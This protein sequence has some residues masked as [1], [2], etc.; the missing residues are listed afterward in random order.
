MRCKTGFEYF[1][2]YYGGVYS[3]R[4]MLLTGRSGAGKTTFGLQFLKAGIKEDEPGLIIS[5]Q[6]ARNLVLQ[7][8]ELGVDVNDP[9]VSQKLF[10]F[11]YANFIPGRDKEE[12][13]A[14]PVE[15][16]T[17]LRAAIVSNGIRRL[18]LDTVLP[19]LNGTPFTKLPEEMFSFIQMLDDLDVTTVLTLPKPASKAALKLQQLIELSVPISVSLDWSMTLGERRFRINKYLGLM[20]NFGS[21]LV[22]IRQGT[23]L[24]AVAFADLREAEFTPIP[25]DPVA[26]AQ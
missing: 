26:V 9:V 7:M 19:W 10:F 18:V 1:D 25:A 6:T 13:L 15:S 20:D 21:P 8:G 4:S 5:G 23:G 2:E 16:V 22:D 12:S 3:G 17:E 11:D 24:F 14:L